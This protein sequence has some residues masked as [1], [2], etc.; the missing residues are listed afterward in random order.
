MARETK[1]SRDQRH[2]TVLKQ[3]GIQDA[4]EGL[5]SEIRFN[6]GHE[7]WYAKVDGQW[8]FIDARAGGTKIWKWCPQGPL[9]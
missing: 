3:N 8:Y 7:A 9:Y 1:K 6:M 5:V 4:P 2:R